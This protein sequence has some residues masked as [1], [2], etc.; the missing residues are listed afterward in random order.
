MSVCFSVVFIAMY[1]VLICVP[2]V[3]RKFPV[4]FI[5]LAV[6]VSKTL[7]TFIK[8]SVLSGAAITFL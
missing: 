5:C 1:V 3:R 2:T 4:N 6:F 7:H 8:S